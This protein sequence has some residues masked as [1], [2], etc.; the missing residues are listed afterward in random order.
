MLLLNSS[1]K[2]ELGNWYPERLVG[3]QRKYEVQQGGFQGDSVECEPAL[4]AAANQNYHTEGTS[5]E[6]LTVPNTVLTWF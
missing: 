5:V 6:I 1:P 3:A 4:P 2:D